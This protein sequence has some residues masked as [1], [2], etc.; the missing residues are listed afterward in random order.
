MK[1]KHIVLIC[2]LLILVA[3]FSAATGALLTG[4]YF[5]SRNVSDHKINTLW[6]NVE[7]YYY[8]EGVDFS[9][10][11]AEA[12][13]ASY[14]ALIDS[15]GDPYSEYL[16]K[17]DLKAL[18]ESM[19]GSYFGIGVTI[20]YNAETGYVTVASE[21]FQGSPAAAAGI[22]ADDMLIGV[23][24][25]QVTKDTMD[26]A[27][28]YMRTPRQETIHVTWLRDGKQMSADILPSDVL[29][30]S[31]EAGRYEDIAYI[32]LTSFDE[33]TLEEFTEALRAIPADSTRGLILDLRDNPGG[34]LETAVDISDLVLPEGIVVY[35]KDKQGNRQDYR[36]D[37]DFYDIPMVVLVNGGS[38]SASEI[39]AGA[40]KA[41]GRATLVGTTTFGK[42]IV[43]G[44][45]P[46]SDGSAVK[47]TTARYFTPDDV[48]IHGTGIEPD[49]V[50]DLPEDAERIDPLE[51]DLTKDTQ[52]KAAIEILKQ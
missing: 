19:S 39:T 11:Y 9:S 18:R 30:K 8:E 33:N 44:V 46:L 51:F 26:E 38:A 7:K 32:R 45:Y 25:I 10:A 47:L 36:S 5:L 16:S 22:R 3:L 17:E 50:V 4:S 6:K 42:G 2:L 24:D 43:Q 12:K 40:L 20:Y 29:I 13:E 1:K 41:T 52:M 35:T 34:L 14:Y 48:C 49:T 28:H 23:D 27:V 37:A 31:V 21:P 15:L